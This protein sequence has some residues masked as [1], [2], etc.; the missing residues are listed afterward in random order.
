MRFRPRR[1]RRSGRPDRGPGDRL[2]VQLACCQDTAGTSRDTGAAPHAP[3]RAELYELARVLNVAGRSRMTKH[4]LRTAV[5]NHIPTAAVHT[6]H[7][8]PADAPAARASAGRR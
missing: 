4:E 7:A 6:I 2:V 3:T 5:G 8:V 1:P